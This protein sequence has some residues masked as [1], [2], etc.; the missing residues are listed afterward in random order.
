VQLHH[1]W[2]FV[3]NLWISTG[4]LHGC[5]CDTAVPCRQYRRVLVVFRGCVQTTKKRDKTRCQVPVTASTRH[6]TQ[7][8]EQNHEGAKA[9]QDEHQHRHP[10]CTVLFIHRNRWGVSA[11]CVH[12]RVV[13]TEM[14]LGLVSA[15]RGYASA[16][17]L[18]SCHV[19]SVERQRPQSRTH[20]S[21]HKMAIHTAGLWDGTNTGD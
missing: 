17:F 10:G 19:A 16:F 7:V 14:M 3:H 4:K 1:T 6:E 20:N 13:M 5:N 12:R 21:F 2:H 9:Q 8:I 11:A 15:F 18:L